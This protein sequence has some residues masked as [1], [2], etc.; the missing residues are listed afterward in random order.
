MLLA[1]LT[2]LAG[3]G[4]AGCATASPRA[5]QAGAGAADRA[6]APPV[7][8][9]SGGAARGRGDIFLGPVGG[10]YPAGPEIVSRSGKVIW[11]R[12]LP[13]GDAATDFRPQVYRGKE[14]LTWS[15]LTN[16]GAQAGWTD[17]IDNA[18]GQQIAT[19]R[20]GDGYFTDY[21]E[22]LITPHGTALITAARLGTAHLPGPGGGTDQTVIDDAVQ[23]IDIATGRV[24]LEW[25]A[26]AHVPYRDSHEPR[27]A[28]AS[29][30]W[31]WFHLNAVHLDRDGNLLINSRYT[32]TT[33]K[34]SRQTGKIIW[35]LGGR[36]S[37]FR[38]RAAPGQLLDRAGEIFAFQHDPEAI[39]RNEYTFFDDEAAETAAEL[40]YSRVVTVRLDLA[41]KVA[42]LV[43]ADD[44]PER[45]LT[46]AQG[47]AQQL[48]GG[49]LFVGW[50]AIGYISEFGPSGRLLFN[51][52][53]P[54]GVRSY[55]AYLL[56]WPPSGPIS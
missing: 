29:T 23:E 20:A 35:E 22:F 52:R 38:L 56:P 4:V 8:V 43:S 12:P 46:R 10:K 14:V 49:D 13:P 32:W 31:D 30:P 42:T 36:Q 40:G 2:A 9:L 26:A 1:G 7:A 5:R 17:V 6:Q 41:T 24:L 37:S 27:P 48:P 39:G 16:A 55:R 3:A 45:L 33:Y 25:S 51:A 34:V 19:V 53:L 47:N 54:A 50:G 15:Q 28:S 44:Q 18:R 11:F 21:H